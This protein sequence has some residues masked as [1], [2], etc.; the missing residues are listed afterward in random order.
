MDVPSKTADDVQSAP[1]R[2]PR[3]VAEILPWVALLAGFMVWEIG[4]WGAFYAASDDTYIYLGYVKRALVSP[5]QL[6][7]YNAGEHSAGTTGALYYYLLIPVCA[8]CRLIFN[9][10]SIEHQMLCG[11]AALNG[12][13]FVASGAALLRCWRTLQGMESTSAFEVAV[14]F[15]LFCAHP[16]FLWGEFAG[17]ENPLTAL[18]VLLLFERLA[19]AAAP[20][21]ISILCALA[22]LSRPELS[23]VVFWIPAFSCLRESRPARQRIV[24]A[25][26][27]SLLWA[28]L[29]GLMALPCILLTGRA[30]PSA[31]GT[32]IRIGS[33]LQGDFW[34]EG[35]RRALQLRDY[36]DSPWFV[37]AALLCFAALCLAPLRGRW[38]V[39]GLFTVLLG[40]L[41]MR[42]VLGIFDLNVEGR[43]ISY[44]WPLYALG[45]A[46][47]GADLLNRAQHFLDRHSARF[48]AKLVATC[49]LA[50]AASPAWVE[51]Q[52]RFDWHV[53]EMNRLVVEPSRWMRD[54]LPPGSR[55]AMEPAGAIRLITDFYLVDN[56][57]LTTNHFR[58]FAGDFSRFWQDNRVDYVFDY[59]DRVP[60]L[61][62]GVFGAPMRAWGQ[63]GCYR[64][65]TVGIVD[66]KR[67]LV[68]ASEPDNGRPAAAFNNRL[69]DTAG[70]RYDGPYWFGGA[71]LP[72]SLE[73]EFSGAQQVDAVEITT[74]GT[75]YPSE[76]PGRHTPL[77]YSLE[78][79]QG[80]RWIALS[81]ASRRVVPRI[82]GCESWRFP[83]EGAQA[84]DAVRFRCE[85]V[86]CGKNLA[87]VITEVA[88]LHGDRKYQWRFPITDGKKGGAPTIDENIVRIATRND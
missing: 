19:R 14:L 70:E 38:I 41:A 68:S 26:L 11:M 82:G 69:G 29:V 10:W 16:Q 65:D 44:T 53:A 80:D 54:K 76:P 52:R 61:K 30:F 51:F 23:A 60:D 9:N 84:V 63:L 15:G 75:E 32:R 50:A 42:A 1:R 33:F 5:R 22:C 49:A 79:R 27:H 56:V 78:Y 28:G 3:R 34:T 73:A 20:W 81:P 83:L 71:A 12:L 7:S 59:A 13:L 48:P 36:W 67:I 64:V 31:L 57:G 46:W 35:F 74:W 77:D 58:G 45:F 17:M 2:W 66:L 43:Y 21:R 55:I 25:G 87:P 4:Q 39:C 24:R 88:L 47:C 8:L 6:F 72:A 62:S 18:L 86:V 37:L 40:N 85:K